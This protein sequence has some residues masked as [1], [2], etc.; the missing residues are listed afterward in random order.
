MKK[1]FA[2]HNRENFMSKMSTSETL[3]ADVVD[4][5]SRLGSGNELSDPDLSHIVSRWLSVQAII[6]FHD[7]TNPAELQKTN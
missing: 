4:A 2:I 3:P 5:L 1:R 7:E 6:Y